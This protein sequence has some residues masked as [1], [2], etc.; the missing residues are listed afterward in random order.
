MDASEEFYVSQRDL[1][2]QRAKE[3]KVN[4]VK[5]HLFFDNKIREIARSYP[6]TS[7][8]WRLARVEYLAWERFCKLSS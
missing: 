1:I 8:A 7:V 4:Q 5:L 2:I 6:D 3:Q